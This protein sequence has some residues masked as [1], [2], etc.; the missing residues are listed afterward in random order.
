M[1]KVILTLTATLMFG[2]VCVK[3]QTSDSVQTANPIEQH[4]S[5]QAP[6]EGSSQ[7]SS[8][9]RV[10]IPASQVPTAL[11]QTLKDPQYN[12]WENSTVYF[13]K[14]SNQYSV[15]VMDGNNLK[16]YNFDQSGKAIEKGSSDKNNVTPEAPATNDGSS[17]TVK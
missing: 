13:D 1:K 15:E 11:R 10:R 9:Q 7:Y 14:S 4:P 16:T 12:G 2:A 6:G 3:A 5:M 8:G 17:P